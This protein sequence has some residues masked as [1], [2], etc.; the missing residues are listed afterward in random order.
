MP[1]PVHIMAKMKNHA[2]GNAPFDDATPQDAARDDARYQRLFP[3]YAEISALTEL[4][5]KPGFGVPLHSGMGGH[6]LLYLNGVTRDRTQNY[7]VL[8]LCDP[9]ESPSTHG[10]SVSVNAHY[11]NANWVA[12]EGRDFVWR[13]ALEPGEPLTLDA[14]QR[15]QHHAKL[16][17]MLNGIH[18]HDHLFRDKPTGM[19]DQDFMYEISIATDYGARF[20]RDSYHAR[21][22]LDHNRMAAIV[23]YLN[24]LNDPYR[25]GT[26][27]FKW[28]V[29]N[30]NCVHVVHNALAAAGIWA[31]WPTGQFIG[32]AAFNFP[33]PKNE[34]VDLMLRTNDLPIE[35]AHGIYRDK[36]ARHALLQTGALPTK[37]GA[38]AIARKAIPRNDLYDIDR[39]RLI[40]FDNPFWGPYRFRFARI[41][42]EPRYVDLR[43][44][45]QHFAQRY[46]TAL[47][48]CNALAGADKTGFSH[49]RTSFQKQYAQYIASEA[50]N[51]NHLLARFENL[52]EPVAETAS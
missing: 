12:A 13:G 10:V 1:N 31:P 37:P 8:K 25:A 29:M 3:Y 15:T 40:F 27:V 41:L 22:P 45:L 50:A 49:Q 47:E 20:G 9:G 21:V 32:R 51:V 30:N 6:C 48:R 42:R 38:V 33:V 18:F 23:D 26:R 7:P 16:M 35:D 14:Y 36:V 39:L 4:R 24:R 46:A 28:R 19:S 2:G 5:K 17:G 43:S 44:N 34:F 11:K 52:A